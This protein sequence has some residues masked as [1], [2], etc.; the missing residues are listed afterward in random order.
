MQKHMYKKDIYKDAN[1]STVISQT[2]EQLRHKKTVIRSYIK[3]LLSNT[4]KHT[5]N[6]LNNTNTPPRH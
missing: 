3:G 4:R 5:V 2:W 6:A 1:S